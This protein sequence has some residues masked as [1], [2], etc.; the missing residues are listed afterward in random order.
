MNEEIFGNRSTCK[1]CGRELLF[2]GQY[3]QHIG[4]QPRHIPQPI[5]AWN[6][7]EAKKQEDSDRQERSR[8]QVYYGS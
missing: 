3:W 8:N 7:N 6:P 1:D 5:N 2:T 4:M